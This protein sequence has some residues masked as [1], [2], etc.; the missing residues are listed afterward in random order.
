MT[1][2]AGEAIVLGDIADVKLQSRAWPVAAAV[3]E[4]LWSDVGVR[5]AR[6][7]AERFQ[8]HSCRMAA[9]GV[10]VQPLA[11]GAC[12]AAGS[13]ARAGGDGEVGDT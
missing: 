12:P 10:A 11:P 6:E 9:R 5:D 8:Q 7:A 4:R 1:A 13:A 3:A 2:P